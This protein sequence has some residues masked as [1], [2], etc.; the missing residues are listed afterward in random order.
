MAAIPP[1]LGSKVSTR[2]IVWEDLVVKAW[3]SEYRAPDHGIYQF[4]N[5]QKK[6]STDK[7][8][9]GI[10][11]VPGDALLL[12]DGTFHPDMRDGFIAAVGQA[13]SGV[14]RQGYGNY[15]EISK[16][17][18][19]AGSANG[20]GLSGG[21]PPLVHICRFGPTWA[22]KSAPASYKWQTIAYGT[23][24]LVAAFGI[25]PAGS[26]PAAMYSLDY[27]QTWTLSPTSFGY[28]GGGSFYQGSLLY[29]NGKWVCSGFSNTY[30]TSTDGIN[31][32]PN[33]LFMGAACGAYGNGAWVLGADGG[34]GVYRS[35]DG[36][37]FT[38]VNVGSGDAI[39]SLFYANGEFMA[40]GG[41]NATYTSPD[42]V[43]WTTRGT[44]P[45][46]A[47]VSALGFGN[48][49]WVVGLNAAQLGV[50]YS[51]NN[52]VSWTLV[53]TESFV[54]QT[55]D[56]AFSQGVFLINDP[57]GQHVHS[58]TDGINWN[59]LTNLLPVPGGSP[60]WVW[61][62]DFNG[63]YAGVCTQQSTVTAYGT[64]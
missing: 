42:G 27:G 22:A 3:G 34:G 12:A 15:E 9:T 59:S 35:T 37:N 55:Y 43:T 32:T 23:N 36:V 1:N 14:A 17:P 46:A 11:G 54:T 57:G 33:T 26:V 38:N 58:S 31:W 47:S 50:A 2:T 39:V 44:L 7:Y 8:K 48:G 21:N 5:G 6:D 24:G 62:T 40:I 51:T 63:H 28:A 60:Y 10:Y 61:A 19:G 4:S 20:V 49:T 25:N 30:Y 29:G 41:S 45:A 56:C 64:C 13:A 16:D 52:G 53:N 18:T